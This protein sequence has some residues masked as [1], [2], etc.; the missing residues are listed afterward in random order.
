MHLHG[1]N[2]SHVY[3]ELGME[4]LPEEYLPDDYDGPSVGTNDDVVGKKLIP[5]S[6]DAT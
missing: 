2:L 3:E 6:Y 1:R 4:V 5:A